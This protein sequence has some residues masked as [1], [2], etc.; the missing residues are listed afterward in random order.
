MHVLSWVALLRTTASLPS[1]AES[2]KKPQE[3][4]SGALS[5]DAALRVN[6]RI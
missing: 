2:S 4:F 5:S 1:A 6:L 3:S